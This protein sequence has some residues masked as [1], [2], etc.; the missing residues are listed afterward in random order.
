MVQ[1]ARGVADRSGVLRDA[2]EKHAPD[3]E[4]MAQVL[5]WKLGLAK[6]REE[7]KA[8]GE[9][10]LQEVVKRALERVSSFDPSRSAGAWL[11]GIALN[12]AREW[13]RSR[14]RSERTVSLTPDD[15]QGELVPLDRVHDLASEQ[16]HRVLELLDLVSPAERQ[17]LSLRYVEQLDGRNL[18]AALGISD[19][20][21]RV[22]LSR[23]LGSLR[24]AFQRAESLEEGDDY[25]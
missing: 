11:Y 14:R 21:A 18:A 25:E 10:L 5:V 15:S 1:V 13:A 22:R 24:A 2:I 9:E 20:A 7:G 16:N 23:A 12:V 3:L 6:D 19:G 17:I 8:L 4:A